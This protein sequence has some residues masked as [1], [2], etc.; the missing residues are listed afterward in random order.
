MFSKLKMNSLVNQKFR[1]YLIYAIGEIVLIVIGISIAVIINNRVEEQ[2]QKNLLNSI[3]VNI[4]N[5]M[6]LDLNDLKSYYDIYE[7]Q[8]ELY[9]F[10]LDSLDN[11]R[12]IEDCRP[13]IN[14]ITSSSPFNIRTRG[15]QQ[16]VNY[17]EF[18]L[19]SSDSLVFR[20]SNFYA[21][22]E[23]QVDMVNG[24]LL[25]NMNDNLNY[26]KINYPYFKDMFSNK[27][28]KT[29][30]SF[31][32]DNS[33][34]KNRVALGEILSFA[35]HLQLLKSLDEDAKQILSDIDYR[36]EKVSD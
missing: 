30:M 10:V 29:K 7:S 28:D 21:S 33:E 19:N 9:K 36:L 20:I 16:L 13:C 5:D 25:D 6:E 3:L 12:S 26:L 34:F 22:Y 17:K 18:K 15:F 8:E 2:K 4:K 24:L 31:F 35:N 1:R 11:G 27:F 32:N 14:L 23:K